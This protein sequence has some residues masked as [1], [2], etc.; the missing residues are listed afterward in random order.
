MSKE[1]I[2]FYENEFEY[3]RSIFD[4]AYSVVA[5]VNDILQQYGYEVEFVLEV[6]DSEGEDE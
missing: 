3:A 6:L 5:H 4:P 1:I 2:N